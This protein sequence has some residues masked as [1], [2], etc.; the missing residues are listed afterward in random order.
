VSRTDRSGRRCRSRVPVAWTAMV[1]VDAVTAACPSSVPGPG[2]AEQVSGGLPRWPARRQGPCRRAGGVAP[3][4][5]RPAAQCLLSADR[6]EHGPVRP[7]APVNPHRPC[8]F[9][10]PRRANRDLIP[11]R[12]RLAHRVSYMARYPCLVVSCRSSGWVR[13]P[14]P[15]PARCACARC[16]PSSPSTRRPADSGQVVPEPQGRSR[17]AA[18]EAAPSAPG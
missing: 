10:P 16:P 13:S 8:R 5:P 6:A 18:V 1:D 11:L 14:G 7:V 9:R 3:T 17:H 12:G 2:T 15:S 4:G